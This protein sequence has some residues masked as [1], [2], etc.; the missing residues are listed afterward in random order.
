ML[1][2][3]Q[4]QFRYSGP[5]PAWE[6]NLSVTAGE[7]LAIRGASGSGKSTL[8]GLIAGFLQPQR[9]EILWQGHPIHTLK[10][11]QRP[12]TS[13]FQE[14]NLFEHLDVFT[15]IGLGLH[16]GLQLS[17][18]Q[19][20]AIDQAL[21]RTGLSGFGRRRPGE[22]SGGQRQRVALIRAILRRQPLLLLDEPMTGLDPDTRTELH[23][24]L[25]EEKA[26]GVAMLL[27]SHD[28]EDSKILA[29]RHWNL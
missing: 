18:L 21:T 27:A 19:K 5:T 10:P 29:D 16:P 2:V 4:L 28:P 25:L 3:R 11:W 22:L 6:F 8:L 1:D 20:Q 14:H 26:H 15:N 9:G 7:C 23:R 12:V 13:V 24:M 17:D